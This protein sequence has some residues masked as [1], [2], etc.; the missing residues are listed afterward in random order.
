MPG[1]RRLVLEDAGFAVGKPGEYAVRAE[2]PLAGDGQAVKMLNTHY[3]WCVGQGFDEIVFEPGVKY[4]LR[5]RVR[6]EPKAGRAGEAFWMG[7]YGWSRRKDVFV[8]SPKVGEVK[9]GYQWYELPAWTPTAPQRFWIG[10][11]RF[12]KKT[13]ETSS[14]EGVWIDR[15]ELVAVS[16]GGK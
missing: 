2:D 8:L 9:P 6:V 7:V 3:E 14:V 13:G 1:A 4:V 10:P 16:G 15:I 5:A 12:N 11:G